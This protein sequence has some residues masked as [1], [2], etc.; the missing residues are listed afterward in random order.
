LI[1]LH[2]FGMD[3]EDWRRPMPTMTHMHDLELAAAIHHILTNSGHFKALL[4]PRA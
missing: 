1:L 4:A 3:S 2:L